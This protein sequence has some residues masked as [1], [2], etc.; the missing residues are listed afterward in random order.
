M[1]ANFSSGYEGTRTSIV[2]KPQRNGPTQIKMRFTSLKELP[3]G[4]QYLLWQVAPDNSYT[5]L[6]PL[7][8]TGKTRESVINAETALPDF[9]LLI[10]FENA[11][12]STPTGSLV[13]T[14]IK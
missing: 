4:T 1:T 7:T 3:E 14:I 11:D 2:V 10:T 9:G 5:L 8:Q 13:A 12:A 6:G